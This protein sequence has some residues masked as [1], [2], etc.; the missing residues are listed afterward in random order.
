[1]LQKR[2]F[3]GSAFLFLNKSRY[4]AAQVRP[5]QN[6]DRN[7]SFSVTQRETRV[8]LSLW[9]ICDFRREIVS[10]ASF[11]FRKEKRKLGAVFLK[12]RLQMAA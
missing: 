8:N 7:E 3:N 12:S 5:Q 9:F 6:L 11:S 2:K 4:V 1:M 10:F